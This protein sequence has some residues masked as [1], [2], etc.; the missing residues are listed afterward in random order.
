M[1]MDIGKAIAILA[2][3]ALAFLAP[4]AEAA[5]RLRIAIQKTGTASWEIA[6]IKARGLDKAA[7]LDIETTE[8]ASTEAGKIALARR[9][10][11]HDHF[12]LAVGR[13]GARTRRQAPVHALFERAR[14]GDGGEGSPVHSIGDL[15]GRSIGVAGGPIDKS[16]L[17]LRAAGLRA[18]LD[19]TRAARPVYGAPPLVAE[20]LAQ[21]ETDAALEFWNFSADL[22][23]RGFVRAIEMADV[24]KALG[25]TGPV[26]MTGYV[27]SESFA[28]SH[29]D[30]LRRYFSAAAE[31]R[32]ILAEDP[33]AWAPIKARLNLKDNSELEILRKRY[34]EGLPKRSIGDE[35]ADA[36]ILFDA[37]A[38]VGGKELIG[39]ATDFDPGLF[40]D[41]QSGG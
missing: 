19:L 15:A 31:A 37:L 20:K 13:A 41:P 40:F 27:F 14:R 7:G 24:E 4:S 8:L 12:G 5:D 10:R 33:G 25:A 29:K 2:L 18:G 22:E 30:V 9:R 1:R 32:R 26:A 16:W 38:K 11:G 28:A 3:C 36:R 39:E 35:A 17:L 23:R 34:L 21:G 6:V